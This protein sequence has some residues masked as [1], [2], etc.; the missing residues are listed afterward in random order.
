MPK[1]S[2]HHILSPKISDRE[3]VSTLSVLTSR[4]RLVVVEWL[5]L[6][7]LL[8]RLGRLGRLDLL[9][10]RL[11]ICS[12]LRA[13]LFG[14]SGLGRASLGSGGA[15]TRASLGADFLLDLGPGVASRGWVGEAG[16]AGKFVVVNLRDCKLVDVFSLE[17][18]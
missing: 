15:S 8:G 6:D 4:S 2:S 9:H 3:H 14:R 17:K 10:R 12:S 13:T 7:D 11:A 18:C 1:P 16:E 5:F